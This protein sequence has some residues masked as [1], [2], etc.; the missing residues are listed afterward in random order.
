MTAHANLSAWM[1]RVEALPGFASAEALLHFSLGARVKNA[2]A[3]IGF[4][5]LMY[6]TVGISED[7]RLQRKCIGKL[8]V[9]AT[10]PARSK[11]EAGALA[12]PAVG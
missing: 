5:D 1:R 2:R 11:P 9:A 7:G 12:A 10:R 4:T 3:A 8:R 6:A